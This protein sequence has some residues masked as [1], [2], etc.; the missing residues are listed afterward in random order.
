MTWSRLLSS[1]NFVSLEPSRYKCL[2]C[3]YFNS[4][5]FVT[6]RGTVNERCLNSR[7][8]SIIQLVADDDSCFCSLSL[9]PC[10]SAAIQADRAFS[11][12]EKLRCL[13]TRISQFII[14]RFSCVDNVDGQDFYC[15]RNW[16]LRNHR[17]RKL[18]VS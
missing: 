18:N 5:S 16:T 1:G 4:I 6:V 12:P 8:G 17:T 3:A 11:D 2:P 14:R 7:S 15:G 13:A 9:A 10:G